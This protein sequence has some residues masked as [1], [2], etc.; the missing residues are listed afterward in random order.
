MSE[1][2]QPDQLPAEAPEA[3]V[4]ADVAPEATEAEAA[5]A[6]KP[7]R[8]RAPRKRKPKAEEVAA[9]PVTEPEVTEPEVTAA[10]PE[11][12]ETLAPEP[13]TLVTTED[14]TTP[15][16][17]ETP[18]VVETAAVVE[19]PEVVEAPAP[20]EAPEPVEVP[21]AVSELPVEDLL[22]A[23]EPV[24][25]EL[26]GAFT[27]EPTEAP[28]EAPVEALFPKVDLDET[29]PPAPAFP[30]HSA[31]RLLLEAA[32]REVIAAGEPM[33]ILRR[34][35]TL[36]PP[37][38]EVRD[39]RNLR[40]VDAVLVPEASEETAPPSYLDPL[41]PQAA[42]PAGLP[43]ITPE[44]LAEVRAEAPPRSGR[45]R[46]RDRDRDRGPKQPQQPPV[47]PPPAPVE[48]PA[49]EPD[50]ILVA[51]ALLESVPEDWL[52]EEE[53][54]GETLDG[55]F[56]AAP[57]GGRRKRRRG[58]DRD[59]ERPE[60]NP[61]TAAP[62]A[63][64]P[65]VLSAPVVAAPVSN[66]VRAEDEQARERERE[67]R[68]REP[69]APEQR[70]QREYK[71]ILVNVGERETRIAV[72]ENGRL[73]ELHVE[74]EERV[75]GGVYKGRVSNV[76][77]GMD[78]AFVD[79]GLE[80]NA[81]LYVGDILFEDT[82][83]RGGGDGAPVRRTSRDIR[84]KDVA[85]PGQEIL[86]QVVKGPRG[87]KGARVSTKIS[88]PGRYLVLMPEGDHQGVSRKI[89]DARERDRLKRIAEQLKPKGF[90]LIVRTEAEGRTEAELHQDL[91]Y[92]VK[93]W[94]DIVEK[95]KRAHAPAIL[96]K[97]LGIILKTIRDLFGSDVDKLVVDSRDEYENAVDM[98]TQLAPD[99]A[100]RV[101]LYD[102]PEPI[103]IRYN[104]EEEIDRLL[105]RKVWLRN[106][107][108]LLL[109]TTEALTTIDVNTGKF[110]GST[111]LAETILKTN[112]DAV[113]EIA[114]QLRLRDIGGMIV[115]DFI[116]MASARDR[117]LVMRKLEDAFK[118]DR[119]R[120]K[121]AH[122][123]PLGLVEMTRKRTAENVTD[124]MSQ[125][126][127]YC[128][129]R[130]RVWSPETMA[131]QIEREVLRLCAKQEVEAVLIHANPE[132]AAWLIGAEGEGVEQLERMIRRPVYIRADHEYHVEKYELQPGDMLEMER[133]MM[134]FHGG[135][136]VD[137]RVGK[138]DLITP[139]R[140]AAWAGGYFVDLAN[141]VRFQGQTIRVR[142]TDVRRSFAIGEPVAPSNSVD[143]SEPI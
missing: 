140:S 57:G 43:E 15:D 105:R 69:R 20:V 19:T 23:A 104:V 48:L 13:L 9:D 17:V 94:A 67:R 135:Q 100:D 12:A 143:R 62:V 136:I 121:I 106:G 102:E 68:D 110:V 61:T 52:E 38:A 28:L 75:V 130:G 112:M 59:R 24:T 18:E 137:C 37:V 111:S 83:G 1:E 120:I 5:P 78:A 82:G 118:K 127:P 126:C 93:T 138:I 64:K 70:E 26:P 122:I 129:G 14:V 131:I 2:L 88:I 123:S 50:L 63:P 90:G 117:A 101:H 27:E 97:D 79:I 76:L 81:F 46:D 108:Y 74:R 71:E 44:L 84:I 29:P 92:L 11:A 42:T 119:T 33:P 114:R 45:G 77:P 41:A 34:N 85:K 39:L 109:D 139:P 99:L 6:P 142:L 53:T 66:V 8:P 47:A 22:L 58:R 86:V 16:D 116:D 35:A 10:E 60:E 91:E 72:L 49:A 89:E 124:V 113:D 115:L 134:A 3:V 107:A 132:V 30:E 25:E 54:A 103:L 40:A 128:Q 4:T 95:N 7:R 32:E 125:V 87:T 73:V 65:V 56:P 133:Q 51:E 80:R 21:E 96:H 98:L 141:G 55:G 31:E 36:T